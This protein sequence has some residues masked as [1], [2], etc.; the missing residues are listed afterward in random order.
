MKLLVILTL[1][2][3]SACICT[4]VGYKDGYDKCNNENY[5]SS[6]KDGYEQ[7][8]LD[9]KYNHGKCNREV[10]YRAEELCKKLT[11][12]RLSSNIAYCLTQVKNCVQYDLENQ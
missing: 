5:I 3:C 1:V 2:F 4:Y 6:F 11:M 10:N 9:A 7:G 8:L 12:E